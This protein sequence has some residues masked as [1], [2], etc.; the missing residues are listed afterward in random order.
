L[1]DSLLQE[2]AEV[3]HDASLQVSPVRFLQ[4]RGIMQE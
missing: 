2:I 1:L 3:A 4:V